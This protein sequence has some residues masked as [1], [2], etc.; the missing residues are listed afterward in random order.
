M[1]VNEMH[2]IAESIGEKQG[3]GLF[4]RT[5]NLKTQVQKIDEA[6][7]LASDDEAI[8]LAKLA[9]IPCDIDGYINGME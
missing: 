1:T 8:S 7:I 4:F 6:N 3:W 2:D 9:G 5:D